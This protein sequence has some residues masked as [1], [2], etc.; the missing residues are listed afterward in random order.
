MP[1]LKEYQDQYEQLFRTCQIVDPDKQR[2]VDAAIATME[3]HQA[4]YA[5]LAEKVGVPWYFIAVVHQREAS[6]NFTGSVRD[7]HRLPAGSSWEEDA[8]TVMAEQCGGWHNWS[9]A[10]LLYRLEA[11]NGFGYRKQNINT[12]YLWS[13]SNHYTKGKY[14]DRNGGSWFDPDQVDKQPGAAVILH[15]MVA[16]GRISIPGT[17]AD[18]EVASEP[19]APP[20]GGTYEVQP[21]DTLSGIAASFGLSWEEL[22]EAN[23]ETVPDS[24]HINVGQELVIPGTA[25]TEPAEPE[26][27]EEP[28]ATAVYTVQENDTLP[29]IAGAHGITLT[30]LIELN[31]AL[32]RAG[33]EL[34]VPAPSAPADATP[35]GQEDGPPWLQIAREEE[36]RKVHEY[37][38]PGQDNPRIIGYLES[39]TYD[40]RITDEVYWCSAFVNWCITKA[41]F[42]GT[43]SAAAA[44]WLTWGKKLDRPRLGCVTVF[45]HHVGF[46]AGDAGDRIRLLGGNQSDTVNTIKRAKSEVLGYRWPQEA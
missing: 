32:I 27:P 16:R 25:A 31:P 20:A 9:V 5:A 34:K 12:P 28:P 36:R 3:A 37:S 8:A 15:R 46:Y 24:D 4:R 43:N 42:R 7:G 2:Q 17:A 13:F 39:T 6:G 14:V 44:S 1:S 38:A 11:Y 23:K 33:M 45:D 18:A 35:E 22:W 30:R 40:G 10:G 26:K 29:K 21:G 19:E 41:G